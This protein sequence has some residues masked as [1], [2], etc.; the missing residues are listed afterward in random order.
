[1]EREGEKGG[2]RCRK[3][4]PQNEGLKAQK[5]TLSSPGGWNLK[6]RCQRGG[7]LL[8]P[9]WGADAALSC[10][11]LASPLY[12]CL[13]PVASGQEDISHVGLGPT[14]VT[15]FTLITSLRNLSQCSHV[16][17]GWG[18]G[19]QHMTLGNTIQPIRRAAGISPSK[20]GLRQI[21]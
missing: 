21:G 19:L 2:S 4:G 7:S 10:P 6:S 17:K 3:V 13:C 14:L 8:G 12:V 20:S 5:F 15:S 11:H 16:L 9:P 1:M 18:S